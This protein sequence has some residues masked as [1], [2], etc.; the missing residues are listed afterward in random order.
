M[1]NLTQWWLRARSWA[2]EPQRS[3]LILVPHQERW[4]RAENLPEESS[5]HDE[6]S[7]KF[8]LREKTGN[9]L[10]LAPHRPP[11]VAPGA[12]DGFDTGF[13]GC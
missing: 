2:G 9:L 5:G 10:M 11:S 3:A 13:G 12:E 4:R 6:K 1:A 7:R 8:H